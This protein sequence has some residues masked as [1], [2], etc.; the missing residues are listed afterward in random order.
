MDP[1]VVHFETYLFIR[2]R[3]EVHCRVYRNEQGGHDT[4]WLAGR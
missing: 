2:I 3:R 4:V 1:G